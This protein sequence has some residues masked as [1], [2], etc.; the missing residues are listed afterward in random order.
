[1]AASRVQPSQVN[2]KERIAALQQRNNV[3]QSSNGLS[4]SNSSHPNPPRNT[5]REKIAKFE[6]KGG[7]PIPR[8]SFGLGAPPAEE[9]AV[10]KSRELYGNRIAALGQGRP[11]LAPQQVQTRAVTAPSMPVSPRRRYLSTSSSISGGS[12]TLSDPVASDVPPA[13]G[14]SPLPS[15]GP[16]RRNSTAALNRRSVID[17]IVKFDEPSSVISTPRRTRTVSESNVSPSFVLPFD[18]P[19]LQTMEEAS[20]VEEAF[21][22][23]LKDQP[24]PDVPTELPGPVQ[25]PSLA[26]SALLETEQSPLRPLSPPK[27]VQTPETVVTPLPEI[28][29]ASSA[30]ESTDSRE[31]ISIS[32]PLDS[33]TH[34][35]RSP[36]VISPPMASSVSSPVAV[37]KPTGRKGGSIS[38]DTSDTQI[39]RSTRS[40]VSP[41]PNRPTL[42]SS[43]ASTMSPIELFEDAVTPTAGPKGY[44]VVVHGRTSESGPD[45]VSRPSSRTGTYSSSGHKNSLDSTG[46]NH[47]H[48]VLRSKRQFKH[49]QSSVADPP[50]S[51]SANEL[52]AL[53]QEAAWLEQRLM[54]GNTSIQEPVTP[55]LEPDVQSNSPVSTHASTTPS[56]ILITPSR[57][58][59]I[60]IQHSQQPISSYSPPTLQIHA[61]AASAADEEVPPTPPPKSARTRRYFSLRSK[62]PTMPGA[63]PRHSMSSEISSEDSAPVTTPPS[64]T[65]DL[66]MPPKSS[67]DGMSVKSA[68]SGRSFRSA[69]SGKS[70]KSEAP[71][72]RESLKLSPR[73]GV[74]RATSFA[75]RLLNRASRTKSIIED[76]P[77]E[78][79]PELSRL[80]PIPQIEPM[81]PLPETPTS[82]ISSSSA[83][84]SPNNTISFDRDIFDAF[85][86]VPEGLP[87]RPASFLFPIP[88]D[89]DSPSALARSSTMPAR[90]RGPAAQH[91]ARSDSRS[92]FALKEVDERSPW[93]PPPGGEKTQL[94]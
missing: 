52:T 48:P 56:P 15:P 44:S 83:D 36:S 62:L 43:L 14:N 82:F 23:A 22:I 74:A 78:P 61:P 58:Q 84:T 13:S 49:L 91:Q 8:G 76:S 35:V 71:S 86:S 68:K 41:L 38:L 27:V 69:L 92:T 19:T 7:T 94:L 77:T 55:V 88:G 28:P 16:S 85:P 17:I 12:P 63:Y 37:D 4:S 70:G 87:Q 66:V 46:S 54:D 80:E 81:H 89:Q 60:E 64:P 31:K 59:S 26:P 3:S 32:I 79:I 47:P 11:G 53:L 25:F 39:S 6:E 10:K 73:R 29:E 57:L 45:R 50:A 24:T 72:M 67:H 42:E 1:M 20:P 75:E 90:H 93:L 33:A 5:L 34:S 30:I 65:F 40:V 2:L 18:P 21:P 51:P 9:G